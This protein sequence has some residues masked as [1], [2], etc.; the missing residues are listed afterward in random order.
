MPKRSFFRVMVLLAGLGGIIYLRERTSSIAGCMATSFRIATPS[1]SVE[2][3]VRARLE[4][5]LDASAKSSP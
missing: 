3:G 4:V 2:P 5:R 1:E